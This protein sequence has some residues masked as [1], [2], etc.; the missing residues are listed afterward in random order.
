MANQPK[1]V[2]SEAAALDTAGE[3][4]YIFFFRPLSDWIC[5]FHPATASITVMHEPPALGLGAILVE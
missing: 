2:V 1:P 5:S 3:P 4:R